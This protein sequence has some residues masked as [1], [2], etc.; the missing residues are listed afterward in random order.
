MLVDPETCGVCNT[1][2]SG[3]QETLKISFHVSNAKSLLKLYNEELAKQSELDTEDYF[4]ESEVKL[5]TVVEEEIYDDTM[6]K[7]EN[8]DLTQILF[9]PD[10]NMIQECKICFEIFSSRKALATHREKV[11][12][13]NYIYQVYHLSE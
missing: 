12:N 7:D 3:L 1:C 8:S 4:A 9:E 5:E 11:H 10:E 2:F 6:I 13:T